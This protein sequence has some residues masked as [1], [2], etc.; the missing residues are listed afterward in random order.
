MAQAGLNCKEEKNAS[1]DGSFVLIFVFQRKF[2]GEAIK[3]F[4]YVFFF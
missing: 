2:S 4:F 3:I 1:L